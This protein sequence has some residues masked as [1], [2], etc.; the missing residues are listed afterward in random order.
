MEAMRLMLRRI[1]RVNPYDLVPYLV[2]EFF[3][4][5]VALGAAAWKNPDL[6]GETLLQSISSPSAKHRGELARSPH[7]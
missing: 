6:F 5:G 1:L 2:S 4:L 3:S 7:L